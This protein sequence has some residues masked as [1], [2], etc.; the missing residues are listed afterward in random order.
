MSKTS[1]LKTPEF[2]D[3]DEAPPVTQEQIDR[4]VFR[5]GGKRVEQGKVRVEML[6][7]AGV[8]QF[9]KNRAGKRD[10]AA[11]IN[12]ALGEYVRAHS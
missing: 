11:L 8:L 5:V 2:I 9:F 1:T 4:A 3:P 6:L 7:D 10:C 12:K